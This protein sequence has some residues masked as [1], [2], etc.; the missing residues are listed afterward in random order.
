MEIPG[1]GLQAIY[2]FEAFLKVKWHTFFY[3]KVYTVKL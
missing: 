1:A 2:L 3:M